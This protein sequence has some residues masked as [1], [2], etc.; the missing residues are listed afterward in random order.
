MDINW[1]HFKEVKWWDDKN[2]SV[3]RIQGLID[4]INLK[5]DKLMVYLNTDQ[6]IVAKYH[7]A[8]IGLSIDDELEIFEERGTKK[9]LSGYISGIKEDRGMIRITLDSGYV[10]LFYNPDSQ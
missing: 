1:Y 3:P 5:K 4:N 9:I 6:T 2:S 8:E 7:S 10:V